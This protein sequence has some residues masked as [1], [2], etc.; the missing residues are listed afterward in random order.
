MGRLTFI[1]LIKKQEFLRKMNYLGI[2]NDDQA[3]RLF[4]AL[5]PEAPVYQGCIDFKA[6]H[7]GMNKVTSGGAKSIETQGIPMSSSVPPRRT[8]LQ[9][10][11]SGVFRRR[12]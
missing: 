9:P 6:F 2:C 5:K 3:G 10:L 12:N 7:T 1:S 4:E 8:L 11:D